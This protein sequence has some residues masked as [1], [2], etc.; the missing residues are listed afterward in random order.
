MNNHQVILRIKNDIFNGIIHPDS[1]AIIISTFELR[2]HR[3][4]KNSSSGDELDSFSGTKR[5]PA[6]ERQVP[7]KSRGCSGAFRDVYPRA[8]VE[9]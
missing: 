1:L 8:R 6:N 7:A 3:S 5:Q 4:T 9:Q 2:R